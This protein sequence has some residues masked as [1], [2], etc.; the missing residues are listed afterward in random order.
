MIRLVKIIALACASTCVLAST[1]TPSRDLVVAIEGGIVQGA[2]SPEYPNLIFF[3]G[4]RMRLRQSEISDGDR[5]N[6]WPDGRAFAKRR[7]SVLPVRNRTHGSGFASDCSPNWEATH[8]KP[9]PR[10][11]QAKTVSI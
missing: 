7:N 10:I 2:Q 3:R 6:R 4:S 1:Q 5:R 11:R 8:P 9:G